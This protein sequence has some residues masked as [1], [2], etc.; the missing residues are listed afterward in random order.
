MAK[1]T[2]APRWLTLTQA[3]VY[4]GLGTR[5]L[6]NH[7]RAGFIRSSNACAPGAIRGR[8]LIDRESLDAFIEAGV[9]KISEL[10]MNVKKEMENGDN[11][12]TSK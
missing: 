4:S 9:G 1:Q 3:T 2:I 11:H 10:A 8:R 12:P 7:I 6:Q 5:A